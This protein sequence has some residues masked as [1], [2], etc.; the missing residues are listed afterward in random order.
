MVMK[1]I[2][3]SKHYNY[4]EPRLVWTDTILELL[5]PVTPISENGTDLPYQAP[6][7]FWIDPETTIIL[8]DIADLYRCQLGEDFNYTTRSESLSKKWYIS[9]MSSQDTG[10]SIPSVWGRNRR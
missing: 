3:L 5:V 7:S 10:F 8:E 9:G 1:T 2:Y 6:Y 4:L